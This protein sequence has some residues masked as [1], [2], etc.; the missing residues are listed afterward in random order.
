MHGIHSFRWELNG[1]K[2]YL[3]ESKFR[4]YARGEWILL[5]FIGGL[6][7]PNL[8]NGQYRGVRNW[9]SVCENAKV[10]KIL[11]KINRGNCEFR[12]GANAKWAKTEFCVWASCIQC[13]TKTNTF[14]HIHFGLFVGVVFSSES[15]NFVRNK[16]KIRNQHSAKLWITRKIEL[17]VK[18]FWRWRY[19]CVSECFHHFSYSISKTYRDSARAAAAALPPSDAVCVRFSCVHTR[20]TAM[21]A[22][23]TRVD[24][25]V[26]RVEHRQRRRYYAENRDGHFSFRAVF[27][28]V[29]S[30]SRRISLLF[31]CFVFP[32]V[33]FRCDLLQILCVSIW[34][35]SIILIHCV[36]FDT[37][38]HTHGTRHICIGIVGSV[39]CWQA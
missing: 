37:K 33:F 9:H 26:R 21:V 7:D 29:V 18:I 19:V 30:F 10:Q 23:Q 22:R 35:L 16:K 17:D 27:F 34:L 6:I 3:F 20:A 36:P 38:R 32:N 12:K 2:R 11:G 5:I 24:V 31:Y 1:A 25:C 39:S 28:F 13:W 15:E 4:F 8:S 14:F